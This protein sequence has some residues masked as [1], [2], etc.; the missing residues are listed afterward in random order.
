[1]Q[2]THPSVSIDAL[3]SS[4][5]LAIT[6]SIPSVAHVSVPTLAVPYGGNKQSF[7]AK[8]AAHPYSAWSSS[9]AGIHDEDVVSL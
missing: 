9:P 8:P 6:A 7:A 4:S 1:M 5:L 2:G 3:L